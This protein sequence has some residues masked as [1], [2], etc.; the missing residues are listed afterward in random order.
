MA[1]VLKFPVQ[2]KVI[3]HL[4]EGTG[5]RATARLCGV[6]KDAVMYLGVKV[7]QGCAIVHDRLMRGVR[8]ALGEV[9]EI[10]GYVG[11]HERRKLPTDPA[12]WG[13]AYT[14]FC[15]DAVS[16]VVPAY[17]TAPRDLDTATTF[18]RDLRARTVGKPQ[19]SVDG[20]APW[21]EAARRAFGWNGIHLG[22]VVK[23]YQTPDYDPRNPDRKYSPSRVKSMEKF[24]VLGS[25][26]MDAVSTSIAERLNLTGRMQQRR[27]TRLT[28]AYSK[29]R[30]N[31]IAAI[32]LHFAWVNFVRPHDA[33]DGMTPAVAAGI[34]PAPWSLAE[35]VAAALEAV[36]ATPQAPAPAP[37]PVAPTDPTTPE[38]SPS[39]EAYR[40][41]EQ[42]ELPGVDVAPANDVAL[43]DVDEDEAPATVRDPIP[44]GEGAAL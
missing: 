44:W 23:E 18:F 6:D 22:A 16:K 25:P 30:D 32:H 12:E 24:R 43:P 9:D 2:V 17:L 21:P 35:L 41:M 31:L 34:V 28:N 14:M 33:L 5:V 3:A 38:P 19:V 39:V 40:D 13:D 37:A 15:V 11:K 27:L 36:E 10:W 29:K 7:G 26:D 8:M 1:N 4:V 20:W 42:V